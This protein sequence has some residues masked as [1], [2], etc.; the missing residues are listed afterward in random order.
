M[1][2]SVPVILARGVASGLG[3]CAGVGPGFAASAAS[4]QETP[5]VF[6]GNLFDQLPE[7]FFPTMFRVRDLDGDG[8]VD[9]AIAGR[10]PADRVMTRRGTGDGRFV[11]LQTLGAPGF[12]DWLE[13]ADVDGDGDDDMVAA[14]RG[15][16]PRL[17]CYRGIGIGLFDE[18]TVLA[19]VELG[20]VGRDPQSVALGDFDRDGDIDI[21][22]SNYIGQ[23]L[24][25]FSN[26]GAQGGGFAFERTARI[27]LASFFGG[28]AYPR[29]AAAGD[30]DG[31]G[32]LDLVVNE[33]GGTRLAVLRN[34][35][36]RFARPLEYR[37]PEIGTERP[38]VQNA[39]NAFHRY[40]VVNREFNG[41]A[42]HVGS[43]R[44]VLDSLLHDAHVGNGDH[45]IGCMQNRVAPGDLIDKALLVTN[46]HH[47]S[48][49]KAFFQVQNNAGKQSHSKIFQRK[50]EQSG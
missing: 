37:A 28:V 24:D 18:A 30:M 10:D 32:D 19:D 7:P 31:D 2:R 13:V 48:D 40:V 14:W 26:R 23:S 20:G 5:L 21:A 39:F 46:A 38:G 50:T 22:V 1:R 15:D 36:G 49:L 3:L 27:R 35:G 8:F 4:G 6:Q 29:V 11:P 16:V 25:V 33:V 41:T 47:I 45:P 42:G 43:C 12:I 17:V 34:D 44:Q 9:L